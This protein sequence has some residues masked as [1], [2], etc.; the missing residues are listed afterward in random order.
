MP[1]AAD[2]TPAILNLMDGNVPSFSGEKG[3]DAPAHYLKFYDHLRDLILLSVAEAE[4]RMPATKIAKFKKTLV[5]KAR[6]WFVR[7][8]LPTTM[9]G[10]RTVFL[11]K[12]SKDPSRT[13]DYVTSK[14]EARQKSRSI[15]RK[16]ER[17]NCKGRL[18]E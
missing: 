16:V 12:Y 13:E 15:W 3:E 1:R 4:I 11:E 8:T 10:L 9:A 18:C 2:M 6:K 5:G 14:N 17:S 7:I